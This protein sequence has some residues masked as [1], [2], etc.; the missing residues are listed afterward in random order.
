MSSPISVGSPDYNPS[1]SPSLPFSPLT[2]PA[3]AA[4]D[5]AA[6]AAT[7]TTTSTATATANPTIRNTNPRNPPAARSHSSS[8][9]S[10]SPAP[11][12]GS[13]NN[14]YDDPD[15]LQAA[16]NAAPNVLQIHVYSLVRQVDELRE[17]TEIAEWGRAERAAMAREQKWDIRVLERDAE[18]LRAER[19]LWGQ[20]ADRL[21]EEGNAHKASHIC[22]LKK[23]YRNEAAQRRKEERRLAAPTAPTSPATTTGLD[24]AAA[25]TRGR[26]TKPKTKT[27]VVTAAS[28]RPKRSLCVS[29]YRK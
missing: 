8:S 13:S 22:R 3:A 29:L 10:S 15:G 5:A 21:R 11:S 20:E 12:A 16:I 7:T 4:P 27:R 2:P 25:A 19:D 14:N 18:R 28:G 1:T 23:A 17:R 26:V 24:A 9:S 6:A